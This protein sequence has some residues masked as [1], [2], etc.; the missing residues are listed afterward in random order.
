MYRHPVEYLGITAKNYSKIGLI[1][2]D[3]DWYYQ[4]FS[5]NPTWR[6]FP[7]RYELLTENKLKNMDYILVLNDMQTVFNLDKS[8]EFIRYNK[9]DFNRFRNFKLVYQISTNYGP[10]KVNPV[11]FYIYKN[12]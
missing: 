11:T 7:L 2:S 4:F 3:A 5:Q 9:I 6:I 8:K 10:E 12:K 1:L